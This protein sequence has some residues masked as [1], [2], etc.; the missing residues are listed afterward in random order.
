MR[1]L[2]ELGVVAPGADYDGF[3][4]TYIGVLEVDGESKVEEW[5]SGSAAAVYVLPGNHDF[6]VEFKEM[7]NTSAIPIV[8]LVTLA[9]D[10]ATALSHSGTT[11]AF[12]VE[13]GVVHRTHYTE[14]DEVFWLSRDGPARDPVEQGPVEPPDDAVHCSTEADQSAE[15]WCELRS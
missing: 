5:T 10:A 12:P 2:E 3:T 15:L 8:D 6:E 14:D 1:P 4:S 13:A 9:M 7:H 11:I